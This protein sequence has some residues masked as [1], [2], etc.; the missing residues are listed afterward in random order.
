MTTKVPA[1]P[2]ETRSSD[3]APCF[4]H[5]ISDGADGAFHTVDKQ[6]SAD[7][8]RWRKAERERLISVRMAQS[9]ADREALSERISAELDTIIHPGSGVIVSLYW[10]FRGEPNLRGWME[11]ASGKG[12]RMALPVVEA[13]G[14]PLIFRE[15]TPGAKMERGVWNILQPAT[16]VRLIP[17]IVISP[18]VGFDR[19]GYRLGYGGGFYDRTL[20]ALGRK[21]KVIGVGAPFQQVSTIYPQVFDVPMDVIVTGTG[22]PMR[23]G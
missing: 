1:M 4:A 12:A 11:R 17:D 14:L 6:Q 21:P 9:Q 23:R 16:D 7:V 19:E 8:A 2:D 10:P 22:M 5:E 3:S 13:K 18:L 20:A 15:W